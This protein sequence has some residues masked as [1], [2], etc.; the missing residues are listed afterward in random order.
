MYRVTDKFHPTACRWFET[1]WIKLVYLRHCVFPVIYSHWYWRSLAHISAAHT[2]R[3]I[4]NMCCKCRATLTIRAV[5][6][7]DNIVVALCV[8]QFAC[9]CVSVWSIRLNKHICMGS[10]FTCPTLYWTPPYGTSGWAILYKSYDISTTKTT[11]GN[12]SNICYKI[13]KNI[14]TII[15]Y[16]IVVF[17]ICLRWIIFESE[18]RKFLKNVISINHTTVSHR[19]LKHRYFT[20]AK[21]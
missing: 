12:S 3:T 1:F 20:F 8:C 5:C 13:E 19:P 11:T 18:L 7:R 9:L 10:A 15:V 16:Y 6:V 21:H 4:N 17:H 14:F 2:S